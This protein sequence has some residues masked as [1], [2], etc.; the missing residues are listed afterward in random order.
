MNETEP[1][2]RDISPSASRGARFARKLI[3]D[4]SVIT[5]ICTVLALLAPL[6][7]GYM[8]LASRLAYWVALGFAGYCF[9]QPLGY[10]IIRLG[11]RLDLPE[12]FLWVGT[13]VI[14]TVPMSVVVWLVNFL[15]GDVP[16]P[17]LETALAHYFSVLI[18]GAVITLFFNLI[19]ATKTAAAP[20]DVRAAEKSAPAPLAEPVA[21]HATETAAPLASSRFMD[22]LPA[23][24]GT[25]LLALEMEDHYVRAHTALG[26]DLILMRMRDAIPELDGLE[27]KQVHRSW[28]VARGA[29]EDVRREGRNVRL[30]L[31]GGLEAPVSRAN[32]TQLKDEG[33]F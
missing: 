2:N 27:G 7:T 24:L 12:W 33:W 4:A 25:D 9:Y 8:P 30:I 3:I 14:A 11:P 5:A 32:V 23:E 29:V 1:H 26:S 22:R 10:L 13:V 19:P 28:W 18:I 21:E 20:D 17:S 16:V 6:G 31:A 15:P